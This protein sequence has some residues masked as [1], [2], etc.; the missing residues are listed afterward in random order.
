LAVN[1]YSRG[2]EPKGGTRRRALLRTPW[3]V[4]AITGRKRP[5]FN[6]KKRVSPYLKASPIEQGSEKVRQWAGK[7]SRKNFT[8]KRSNKTGGGRSSNPPSDAV[9]G[10]K[11][12]KGSVEKYRRGKE[13]R[14]I[15]PLESV[16][17]R[18]RKGKFLKKKR[19]KGVDVGSSMNPAAARTRSRGVR[20]R[21]RATEEKREEPLFQLRTLSP[22]EQPGEAI[23][24]LEVAEKG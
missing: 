2:F 9:Q 23:H 10:K 24:G 6:Q 5:L 8:R 20:E 16:L 4:E 14:L 12:Q 7:K 15:F 1:V 22:E 3:Q 21:L 18:T 17:L 11:R 19:E 13:G